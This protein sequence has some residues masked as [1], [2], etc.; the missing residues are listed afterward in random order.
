MKRGLGC[1]EVRDLDCR[2]VREVIRMVVV[3]GEEEEGRE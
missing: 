3:G 2:I 1:I